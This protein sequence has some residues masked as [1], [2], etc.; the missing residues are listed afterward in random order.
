M[1]GR[2]WSDDREYKVLLVIA[3]LDD[4]GYVVGSNSVYDFITEKGLDLGPLPAGMSIPEDPNL[5]ETRVQVLLSMD[6]LRLENPPY[7]TAHPIRTLQAVFPVQFFKVRMTAL[8]GSTVEALR[9]SMAAPPGWPIGFQPP[10]SS[11]A[12]QLIGSRSAGR[13]RRPSGAEMSG[14]YY[15]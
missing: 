1:M 7:I 5:D 8:G 13:A 11:S 12:T 10:K 15:R 14:A 4:D 2:S 6:A 9:A 3:A